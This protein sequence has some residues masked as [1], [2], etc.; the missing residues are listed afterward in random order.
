MN[1]SK[2]YDLVIFDFDGVLVDSNDLKENSLKEAL[3][4]FGAD[5][6]I[7]LKSL[8]VNKGKNRK[9][10]YDYS[11]NKNDYNLFN[12]Y[13]KTLVMKIYEDCNYFKD[14][15]TVK[16]KFNCSFCVISSGSSIEIIDFLKEKNLY[17]YF[18]LGVFSSLNSKSETFHNNIN[19]L[20]YKNVLVIGDGVT[21]YL[22]SKEITADFLFVD[23]WTS[24]T[25]D[26]ILDLSY[27]Y[28]IKNLGD[29]LVNN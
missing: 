15:A 3:I 21:D 17:D 10:H 7:T 22:L 11:C 2:N 19:P 6:K 28:K 12:S 23:G 5:E 29:L 25:D 27:D 8:C 9:V 13:Y 26:E 24:L 16:S 14:I 1:I 18:D 4:K 20:D